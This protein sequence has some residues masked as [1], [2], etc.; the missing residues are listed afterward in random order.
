MFPVSY[1]LSS[2]VPLLPC[3]DLWPAEAFG[4]PYVPP[5]LGGGDFV[6]GANF[7]V[8]GATA[9]DYS[10]FRERGVEPTWTPHSL[11]EQMQW[12]KKLLTSIASTESGKY[13]PSWVIVMLILFGQ[14]FFFQPSVWW[15]SPVE[16]SL[17][18]LLNEIDLLHLVETRKV[19]VLQLIVVTLF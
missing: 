14:N 6:N 5:Y 11:N 16:N 4:L 8:G 19:Y 18:C 13:A 9:L 17:K 1:P 15:N 3:Y 10:F 12:F 2:T 7:A